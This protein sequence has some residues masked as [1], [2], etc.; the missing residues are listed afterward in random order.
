MCWVTEML[1]DGRVFA[2]VRRMDN[3][4]VG[5]GAFRLFEVVRPSAVPHD[6]AKEELARTRRNLQSGKGALL[7]RTTVLVRKRC[8]AEERGH[9]SAE[10]WSWHAGDDDPQAPAASHALPVVPVG[11]FP[12]PARLVHG[13]FVCHRFRVSAQEGWKP[14][15]YLMSAVLF[16][17]TGSFNCVIC[18]YYLILCI[19]TA[20]QTFSCYSRNYRVYLK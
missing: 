7:V 19:L 18:S 3:R 5:V 14:F 15:M 4:M 20:I 11:R 6:N 17:V 13:N 8:S 2:V 1:N 12:R 16:Y 10:H 9:C